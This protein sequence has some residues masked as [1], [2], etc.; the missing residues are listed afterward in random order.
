LHSESAET[1]WTTR[2]SPG[3]NTMT[4]ARQ[5]LHSTARQL[6]M[7]LDPTKLQGMTQAERNAVIARLANLLMEAAGAAATESADERV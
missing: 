3:R 2:M 4:S 6:S 7:A 5:D 1:P